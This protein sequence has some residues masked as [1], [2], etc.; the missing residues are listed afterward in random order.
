MAMVFNRDQVRS[1]HRILQNAVVNGCGE[2]PVRNILN[3]NQVRMRSVDA[4]VPKASL[5]VSEAN[6]EV[7]PPTL[8]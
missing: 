1:Y 5:W 2:N 6:Y 8:Y 7:Y 3:L 4:P